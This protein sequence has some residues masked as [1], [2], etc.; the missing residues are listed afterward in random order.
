MMT[1]KMFEQLQKEQLEKELQERQFRHNWKITIFNVF[2]G[3]IAGLITSI[4]FWL[5]TK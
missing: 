1:E 4:I 3:S 2:G 5:T